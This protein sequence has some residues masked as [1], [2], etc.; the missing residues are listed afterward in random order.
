MASAAQIRSHLS[1]TL[2]ITPSPTWVAAFLS[3]QRTTTPLPSLLA[4][5]KVRFLNAEINIAA[6]PSTCL[7]PNIHDATLAEYRL[8]GPVAVQVLDVVDLTQS[9]WSQVEAIEAA[10]RGEGKKGRE[11]IR[12]LPTEPQDEGA[13]AASGPGGMCKLLLQDVNGVRVWGLELKS[14]SGVRVGMNIGCKVSLLIHR[15]R[16]GPSLSKIETQLVLRKVV[17]ARA[18]LLLEPETTTVLG[19]KV[20]SLHKGWLEGRKASLK[21]AVGAVG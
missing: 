2:G 12:V 21:A 6:E 16:Q 8:P 9:R 17:V 7:S 14:V 1:S 18:V 19:G 20:E 15:L 3:S 4:T 5:S 13:L 11:I 10:E